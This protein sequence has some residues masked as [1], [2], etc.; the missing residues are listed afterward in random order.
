MTA[1]NT[2]PLKPALLASVETL[3][4]TEMTPVQ[5]QSLPPMLA[6]RDV[7]AQAQTGSGKTAAFG[8][9]LLQS[10]DVDTIRLQALVL[11]PTRELAD[12]VSKALRKLAANIPNVKLLTLCGGMPLGPQ[13]ASLSHDP[14]IVVGTPGRVQ[15][16]LKRGSL[17]GGGIK[18]L[19]LDEADRMLD[20]GFSEAIDDIVG[21]I[22]KHHQTL[23]F[24]ATYPEEIR[25]V[26][27]RVQTDPVVVT[28]DTPAEQKPAIEQQFIEVEPAQKLDALAQLLAGE[29]G[30]HA[31]VFCNMRRDVDAVAQEL[32]RR[33]YSALAL[34]GDMEQRDRDEVLVRFA[35]KSCN[36]L[37]AT[38]VAARG[39]DIAALPLVLCYDVAHDPDT[40]THRIGRTGRAGETGLA[41]TLCTPR[42]RPKA[43][44]IEEAGGVPL[45]WRTLKVA[46]PRGKTLQL[47]PMKTLVIDAGRQDKLRPGDILGALTGD[48]GLDA[49]DIGKID[50]FATRAYVAI[51]RALAAKS[52]ERLRAGRIKGRNFRVRPLG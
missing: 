15:E 4:Y 23:L 22:A 42:E 14:H 11:C 46:P 44:N 35:N 36:V 33:G 12:Q 34:H 9:S 16:H 20:M 17:H 2:L 38:D 49:K 27:Q 32:D 45:S 30:Q 41:I 18:V 25:A 1:F 3:G 48:A 5:A 10:I 13:L 51:G 50:V 28:V 24:S 31:L 52:L 43:A 6:G 47:A 29:R 8:L 37:V 40:H 21:R 26:S 39:L 19:V 7:I